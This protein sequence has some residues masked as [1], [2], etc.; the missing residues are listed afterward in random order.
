VT[1][2]R[3]TTVTPPLA[4][5]WGDDGYAIDRAIGA[6]A[7]SLG[8]AD[9]PLER[10]MV[11]AE[12]DAGPAD[13]RA[14]VAAAFGHSSTLDEIE[15]RAA[16][17]PLFGGGT[18]IVVRQ[19]ASLLRSRASAE[20]LIGMPNRLAPRNGLAFTELRGDSRRQA[21]TTDVLR[22]AVAAAGGTVTEFR[23]PGRD[24]MDRWLGQR[25]SELGVRLGPGAARLLAERV[26]AYVREGDVDRRNQSV[27]ANAELEKLALYRPAGAISREDVDQLVPEAV[28]GSVWA[29]MDAIAARRTRDAAVLAERLL[30]AGT[31]LPILLSQLHR[32]LRELLD[33]RERLSQG[34]RANELPRLLGV[35]P[36]RAQKLAEQ[37]ATWRLSELEDALEGLLELDL[38][39]KGIATDGRPAGISD[40]RAAMGLDVWIAE[41]VLRSVS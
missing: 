20:R 30:A 33:V 27:L 14:D 8:G 26:G 11:N 15:L 7:A 32:R 17:A 37:A 22:R 39:T 38:E 9:G 19:P 35:Q 10:W 1:P 21:S 4:F 25:A 40:E 41:R 23:V 36:Y 12:H 18:L 2:P 29:F 34:T 31:P 5:F 6:L 16:T 13:G 3:G 24:A 28:P